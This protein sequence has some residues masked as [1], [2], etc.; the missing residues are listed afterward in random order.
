VLIDLDVQ[1]VIGCDGR[2]SVVANYLG[3]SAPKTK[4]GVALRGFTSYSHG[5]PFWTEFLRL[6]GE[7][8]SVGIVPV[9]HNLV[10]FYLARPIRPI[11]PT[12]TY[13]FMIYGT[14]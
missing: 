10:Y 4:P 5:H 6:S 7:E 12:G 8:F 11:P 2:N 14:N 1:V 13:M 9:T 3:L